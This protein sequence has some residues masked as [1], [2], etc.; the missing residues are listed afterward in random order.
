MKQKIQAA[1]FILV[2]ILS[3]L[4]WRSI[5][6]PIEFNRQKE[7]RY[8]AVIQ[9]LKDIRSVQLAYMHVNHRFT[10]NFDTLVHFVKTGY[11]PVV[12][13]LGS[14]PDT[15]SE[16]EA[17]R[18]KLIVRDTLFVKVADS[19]FE[20]GYPVDSLPFVPF[21]KGERFKMKAGFLKVGSKNSETTI[22]LPVFEAKVANRILLK[23][24][25]EQLR[26]NLDDEMINLGK[27]PGLQLG[28]LETIVNHSGNWEL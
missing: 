27:Y 7:K 14:V 3:F 24:L 10:D 1:L 4:V 16:A 6:E 19:L 23:G 20:Q 5:R 25:D 8:K 28:S 18:M 17:L 15:L 9:K 11:I 22:Q 2:V 26:I 21:C 13:A 12:K